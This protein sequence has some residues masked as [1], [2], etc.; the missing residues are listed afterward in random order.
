MSWRHAAVVDQDNEASFKQIGASLL[1]MYKKHIPSCKLLLD[2]LTRHPSYLDDLLLVCNSDTIRVSVTKVIVAA[3][4]ALV[5]FEGDVLERDAPSTCI[6]R[7]FDVYVGSGSAVATAV[8]RDPYTCAC[9]QTP[10]SAA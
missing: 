3:I 6:G 5:P 1:T 10:K 8:E 2:R 9:V 7:V 4:E